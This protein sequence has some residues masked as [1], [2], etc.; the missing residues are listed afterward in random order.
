MLCLTTPLLQLVNE[1]DFAHFN[2]CVFVPIEGGSRLDGGDLV[3][4]FHGQVGVVDVIVEEGGLQLVSVK[5]FLSDAEL[6]RHHL[7]ALELLRS[8]MRVDLCESNLKRCW[9]LL[10]RH[11]VVGADRRALGDLFKLV[12]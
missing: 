2:I 12:V 4:A 7:V 9:L 6:L 8:Q 3:D 11:H 10:V 1:L 5:E